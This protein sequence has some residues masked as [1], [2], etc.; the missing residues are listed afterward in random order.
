MSVSLTLEASQSCGKI[1]RL[2]LKRNFS[3]VSVLALSF[4]LS[5]MNSRRFIAN[6]PPRLS[7]RLVGTISAQVQAGRMSD[8]DQS[9]ILRR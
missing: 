5:V 6:F 1:Y 2:G 3:L 8:M 9:L 4:R 7:T